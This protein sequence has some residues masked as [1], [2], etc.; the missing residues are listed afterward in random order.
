M[1]EDIQVSTEAE[2]D[3][4]DDVFSARIKQVVDAAY[5]EILDAALQVLRN[6]SFSRFS[7]QILQDDNPTYSEIANTMQEICDFMNLFSG[8]QHDC[9]YSAQKAEEYTQHVKC[10]ADAID[11]NDTTALN[12]HF[13]ALHSRS[14]L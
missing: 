12:E 6:C 10:I 5:Q 11:A 14:F 2:A 1:S 3:F 8:T 4:T 9:V 7:I 13:R